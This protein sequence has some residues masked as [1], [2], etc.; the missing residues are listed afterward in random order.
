MVGFGPLKQ[1]KKQ[2]QQQNRSISFFQRETILVNTT[3]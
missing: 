1:K 3:T 2:Q